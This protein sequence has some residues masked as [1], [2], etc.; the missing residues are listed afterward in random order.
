MI[1]IKSVRELNDSEAEAGQ[2]GYA[3]WMRE[4]ESKAG[5]LPEEYRAYIE[6][7]FQAVN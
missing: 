1:E 6:S 7:R 5:P 3:S 2:D 4:W